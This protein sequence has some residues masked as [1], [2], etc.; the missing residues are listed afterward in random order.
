MVKEVFFDIHRRA[1]ISVKKEAPV[2]FLTDSSD[3]RSTLRPADVLVFGW[4]EGK[5][6]CVN[7]TV[8]N[9]AD[10]SKH[11]TRYISPSLTQKV[12]AN[13]RRVGKG[14]SGVETSIFESMLAVRD[15]AE[16]AEAHVLAQGDDVQEPAAEEVP[17]D[18]VP[19]T[20]T[21]PSS[22]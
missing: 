6:A 16:E 10:L 9:I 8:T 1:E 2:N 18:V 12:F 22:S 11:T 20:P 3:E 17:T 5:H 13:M 14:F 15:V 21:S 4:V 19:P 7:L